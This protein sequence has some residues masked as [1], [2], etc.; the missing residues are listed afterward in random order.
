[1]PVKFGISYTTTFLNQGAALVNLYKDGSMTIHQGGVEMGQGL[2]DKMKTV[3]SREFGLKKEAIRIYPVNT[4]VIP[5]TSAT[6]ASTGSD[7]NGHAIKK[8]IDRLKKRL[9]DFIVTTYNIPLRSIVWEN[10]LVYDKNKP[11]I[12]YPCMTW[13]RKHIGPKSV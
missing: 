12:K 5:N 10:S 4:M 13:Y 6:A 8:A 1:M 7:L 3:A 9:N 11:D 2:Y